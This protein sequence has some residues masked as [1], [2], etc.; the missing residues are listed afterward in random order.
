MI[1]NIKGTHTTSIS[2]Q[3]ITSTI[4]KDNLPMCLHVKTIIMGGTHMKLLAL[5]SEIRFEILV[6]TRLCAWGSGMQR[7]TQM[8]PMH[9][10][11]ISQADIATLI[12]APG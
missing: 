4:Q 12:R 9:Q 3:R 11:T 1:I 8:L 5:I 10:K 6:L 2:K 7:V